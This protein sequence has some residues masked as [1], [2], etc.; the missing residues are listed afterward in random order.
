MWPEMLMCSLFLQKCYFDEKVLRCPLTEKQSL[1]NFC[2]R[3]N[4]IS[5]GKVIRMDNRDA[6]DNTETQPAAL[7]I[8]QLKENVVSLQSAILIDRNIF[9]FLIK[10]RFHNKPASC[11]HGISM[12]ENLC[13]TLPHL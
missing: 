9:Y 2:W 11:S 1:K 4:F 10:H 5:S 12:S 13:V 6:S 7:K 8:N 3:R